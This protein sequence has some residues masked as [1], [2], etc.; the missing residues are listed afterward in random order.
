M[1]SVQTY[2]HTVAGDLSGYCRGACPHNF[3][4]SF[5]TWDGVSMFGTDLAFSR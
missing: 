4:N 1:S 3:F 5:R 2:Q